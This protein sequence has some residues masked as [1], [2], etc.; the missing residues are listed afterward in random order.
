MALKGKKKWTV[1][2]VCLAGI[3]LGGMIGTQV[4][5]EPYVIVA[6]GYS[7]RI[8]GRDDYEIFG[9]LPEEVVQNSLQIHCDGPETQVSV[10]SGSTVRM[11]R[12]RNIVTSAFAGGALA[13]AAGFCVF[14]WG[15]SKTGQNRSEKKR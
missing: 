11:E 2:A 10:F 6:K 3:L 8:G 15:K 13:A 1:A 9:E 7:D 4:P 12:F 14:R 5:V